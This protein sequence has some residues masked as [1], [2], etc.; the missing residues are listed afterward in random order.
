MVFDRTISITSLF[1]F[2]FD[3]TAFRYK[4]SR[5]LFALPALLD[6]QEEP[7]SLRSSIQFSRFLGDI[8]VWKSLGFFTLC[9]FYLFFFFYLIEIIDDHRNWK[10][11]QNNS[12]N[13]AKTSENFSGR[14]PRINVTCKFKSNQYFQNSNFTCKIVFFLF[15][16]KKIN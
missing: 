10:R 11:E 3:P 15:F 12:G 9:F 4:L 1:V 5:R 13:A 16:I 8:P 6:F 14:C 2:S 7:N